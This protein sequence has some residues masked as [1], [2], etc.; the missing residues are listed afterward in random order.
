MMRAPEQRAIGHLLGWV[1][2]ITTVAATPFTTLDP[3]NLPKLLV[4]SIGGF[5]SLAFALVNWNKVFKGELKTPV[6][7]AGFFIADLT[8]VLLLSGSAFN[9]EFFGTN[10]RSTGFVAYVGLAGLF[11]AG[12]ISATRSTLNRASWFLLVAGLLSIIYGVL[13]SVGVEPAKWVS[14]YSPV[15]GFLGNPNFQSAFVGFSS[16]MAFSMMLNSEISKIFRIGLLGFLATSLYV[17]KETQAQQGFLVL[18]GGVA[19]IGLFWVYRSKFKALTLPL[20]GL[21]SLGAIVI[22]LGSLNVGPLASLLHKASVIY[23]GDYWRAGWKMTMDHP[24]FGVGLDSYGDWYRRSRTL[25]ATVRRG[26]DVTSNAAHNVLL[27]FSSNGGFPLLL[28]YLALM[29]L[30]VRAAF[31]VI[32]RSANFDPV[33]TG[34]FAVWVAYQAQ[35]IISLNQLGLAVWGW[36]I[37]GLIIGYEINSRN[38]VVEVKVEKGRKREKSKKAISGQTVLPSTVITLFI[39]LLV[40]LML[41]LVPFVASAKY[42]SALETSDKVKIQAAAYIKPLD[43]S[44]MLQVSMTLRDNKLQA[45][46]LSV[47]EDALTHFPDSY[48]AWKVLA[49]LTPASPAQVTEAK[50]QMK[51]LDPHNPELK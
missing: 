17:I 13:Q 5:M 28:I 40:G 21:G 50:A 48:D 15:I 23:R 11:L 2:L 34:L 29:A 12:L 1:A 39:G 47:V 51:R 4:I 45:D 33:F 42:K 24:I 22:V 31:R 46:A 37:S 14:S 36:I 41:G 19:V 43:I 27:D 6:L 49:S 8:L 3:I 32:R 30:V 16:V 7:L 9:Q 38:G 18:L 26:P 25:E 44:R 10:G 20:V 35:S